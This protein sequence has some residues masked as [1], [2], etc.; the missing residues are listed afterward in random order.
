MI[1]ESTDAR[2]VPQGVWRGRAGGTG[3]PAVGRRAGV[4]AGGR[5]QPIAR[6]ESTA[7]RNIWAR[8]AYRRECSIAAVAVPAFGFGR[9]RRRMLPRSGIL[10]EGWSGFN[11]WK[12]GETFSGTNANYEKQSLW[13]LQF[14]ADVIQTHH[15]YFMPSSLCKGCQPVR[16][17]LVRISRRT[18]ILVRNAMA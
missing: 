7:R 2:G 17:N 9:M 3:A 5:A 11:G 1:S 8:G 6:R 10:D 14:Q 18:K 13:A 15:R 16:V 4:R 12:S